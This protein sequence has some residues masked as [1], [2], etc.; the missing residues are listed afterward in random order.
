MLG[1]GNLPFDPMQA[2]LAIVT[3]IGNADAHN[4]YPR[5]GATFAQTVD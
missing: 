4:P 5:E 2:L 3:R 1:S